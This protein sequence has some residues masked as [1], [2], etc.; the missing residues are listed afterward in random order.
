MSSSSSERPY[1]TKL[2]LEHEAIHE[3]VDRDS[4]SIVMEYLPQ[5]PTFKTYLIFGCVLNDIHL[6]FEE[7]LSS[8]ARTKLTLFWI[9][10]N[11]VWYF[12]RRNCT[13]CCL[14]QR[15]PLIRVRKYMKW[16]KKRLQRFHKIQF[17]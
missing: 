15:E 9:A 16:M 17:Y 5:L 13:L 12:H 6:G 3:F 1:Q 14:K 4:T 11:P 10:R 8:Y 7:N 2:R